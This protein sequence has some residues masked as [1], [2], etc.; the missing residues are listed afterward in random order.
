M[1]PKRQPCH[2]VLLYLLVKN[3]L[4]LVMT[5]R[6][7]FSLISLSLSLLLVIN[8]SR[9]DQRPKFFPLKRGTTTAGKYASVAQTGDPIH[10]DRETL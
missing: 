7:Y 6:T 3:I 1:S 2:L 8:S 5:R 9:S 10:E 4:N